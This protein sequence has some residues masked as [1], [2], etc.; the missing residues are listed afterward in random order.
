M[1]DAHGTGHLEPSTSDKVYFWLGRPIPNVFSAWAEQR[2]RSKWFPLRGIPLVVVMTVIWFAVALVSG[3][4]RT[5]LLQIA[6]LPILVALAANFLFRDR[7]RRRELRR[8]QTRDMD[9]SA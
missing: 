1:R 6:S 7:M 8:Y 5:Y 2:I 4:S 9:R 3:R